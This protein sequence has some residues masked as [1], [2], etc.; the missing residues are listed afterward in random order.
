MSAPFMMPVSIMIVA[1]LA[2]LAHHVRQQVERDRRAVELAA[3][4]VGEDDAVD[5]EVD[6]ALGVLDVLHALDHDLARPDLADDLEVLVADRRVH[7]GV[8]Q[9]AD[10]A[11]G[12][13]QRRELELRGREEVVPPP[14]PRDGV[15]DRAEGQLRRDREA[16]ALVAQARARDGGVDGEHERV[17]ARGGRAAR[18]PVRDLA[19]AHDVELEPVASVRVRRLDVLDRG[20]AEGREGERDAGGRRPRRRRRSRPRSA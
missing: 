6:E 14:R 7:R 20:R 5:A 2:D 10:R 9:L 3:A 12:R 8:E 17:E 15:D 11:A 18:E 13:R 4:V 1:S 16:V 19:V